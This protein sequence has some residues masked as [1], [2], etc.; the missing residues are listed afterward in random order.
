MNQAPVAPF[1]HKLGQNESYG[2]QGPFLNPSWPSV[3]TF[4][5]EAK[6]LKYI[7]KLPINRPSGLYVG[8]R[9]FPTRGYFILGAMGQGPG[10]WEK[11][12]V[13]VTRLSWARALARGPWPGPGPG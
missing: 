8:V 6:K 4:S 10:G 2:L 9:G 7:D 13:V 11:F 5:A 3:S 1:G 12:R